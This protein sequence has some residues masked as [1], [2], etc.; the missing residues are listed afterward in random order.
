[1]R[2]IKEEKETVYEISIARNDMQIPMIV[3][4]STNY[5]ESYEKWQELYKQWQTSSDDNKVFVLKEPVVTAFN[6][7]LIREI[8][9]RPVVEQ[10]AGKYKN[11]YQR[12]MIDNG[13]SE[14]FGKH[15]ATELMDGG[16]K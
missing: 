6:P 14:T 5:E 2:K 1:M 8:T 16:Y 10:S 15:N 7:V 12:E 4:R 13:F 9:L 3:Y 11:P